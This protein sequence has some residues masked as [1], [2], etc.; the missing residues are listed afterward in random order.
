MTGIGHGIVGL[1]LATVAMPRGSRYR[2]WLICLTAFVALA[3]LPDWRLPY[4]G[5]DR[6]DISHSL[7]VNLTLIACV[8]VCWRY[9]RSFRHCVPRVCLI[10][11]SVA[12]MSHLLLDSF[13]NHGKGIGIFWPFSKER[14]NLALPWFRTLD[15]SYPLLDHR[16]LSVLEIEFVAYT[17]I[18][19]LAI[20]LRNTNFL[21]NAVRV[22]G[23]KNHTHI[24]ED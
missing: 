17:P 3:N 14:L 12:W 20:F 24:R 8:A 19:L 9:S 16:N 1:S 4:W 23:K 2:G 22:F 6:Y 18:L 7:F 13:Y 15:F 5:H 11:A 10:L 21:R